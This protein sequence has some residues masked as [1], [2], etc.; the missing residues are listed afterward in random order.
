[1][2]PAENEKLRRAGKMCVQ[3]REEVTDQEVN[4]RRL[5]LPGV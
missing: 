4:E 1:M 3:R 2:S 5:A